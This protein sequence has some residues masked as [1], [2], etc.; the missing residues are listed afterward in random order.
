MNRKRILAISGSTRK[1]SS[2]EKLIDFIQRSAKDIFDVTI[3][4]IS[5]LPYFNQ[6]IDNGKVPESVTGFRKAIESSDGI[7]ICTPEYVFSIPGILKNAIEWTVS[8]VV[9]SD[10]PVAVITASSSGI[11][12]HESLVLV[13]K[14]VGAKLTDDS[15]LLIQGIKSK[16]NENGEIKDEITLQK[17]NK[18]IQS[19]HQL[20]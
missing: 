4:D 8:T 19:L 3:F 17:I 11:K 2:N 14:T 13:M 1:Y 9:F 5:E 18:V 15:T 16:L 7:L 12:S 6:D 20:I 10:K